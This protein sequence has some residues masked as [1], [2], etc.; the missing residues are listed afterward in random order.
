[1]LCTRAL[2]RSRPI[3]RPGLLLRKRE[4]LEPGFQCPLVK[5]SFSACRSPKTYKHL[6]PGKYTFEV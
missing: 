2:R 3:K 6:K 1:M 4:Y 5:P